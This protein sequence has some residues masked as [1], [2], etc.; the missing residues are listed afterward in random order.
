MKKTLLITLL[1]LLLVVSVALV[2]CDEEEKQK[3]DCLVTFNYNVESV[4]KDA[5]GNQYIGANKNS[6]IPK[7]GNADDAILSQ[8][9][10]EQVVQGYYNEG[11]Y[12][13]K[14]D[15]K[16]E[17]VVDKDQH[18]V[19]D[20]KWDFGHD[21]VTQNITLYAKL[22]PNPTWK[23]IVPQVGSEDKSLVY[24]GAPGFVVEEPSKR[25][26]PTLNGYTFYGFYQ[27]EDYTIPFTWP[28]VMQAGENTPIYA[29][30]LEGTW[31][32]VKTAREFNS[33]MLSGANI[34]VD[35]DIN[36]DETTRMTIGRN[37]NGKIEGNGHT[38]SGI[39][40]SGEVTKTN[41]SGYGLFA[42][43][44]SRAEISNLT[45]EATY[46]LTVSWFVDDVKVALLAYEI[47]P[48][49][50]LTNVN[51]K[52]EIK[53]VCNS[54]NAVAPTI[55][56]WCTNLEDLSIVLTGCTTDITQTVDENFN[57]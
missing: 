47:D 35:A 10:Q 50:K 44:G 8:Y 9:F 21:V 39:V 26:I 43:L 15:E 40:G 19:L 6:P 30:Y 22:L 2:A 53:C 34:Y 14:L 24:T 32:I 12:L 27:D 57:S 56:E 28:Y 4:G 3:Y 18:V 52:G 25:K 38:I 37:Y 17:V 49:A 5:I 1:L 36:F 16:G 54:D 46:T 29:K 23:I 51:L 7:P 55:S 41:T 42:S 31:Q 20:R 33:A 45:I 48:Q 11:W 13:P